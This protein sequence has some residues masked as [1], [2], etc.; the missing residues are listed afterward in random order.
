MSRD[1]QTDTNEPPTEGSF[2]TGAPVARPPHERPQADDL[3]AT[4]ERYWRLFN[5]PG[6]LPPEGTPSVPAPVSTEALQDL[7]HQV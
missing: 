3:A 7:A 5:D 2:L 6:L 4:S 1:P